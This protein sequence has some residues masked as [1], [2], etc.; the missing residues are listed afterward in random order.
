[1]KFFQNE[2][3]ARTQMAAEANIILLFHKHQRPVECESLL[4]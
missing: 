1:M 4:G 2:E 3:A